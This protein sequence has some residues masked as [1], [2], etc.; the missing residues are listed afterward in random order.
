MPML[1]LIGVLF[2]ANAW[3]GWLLGYHSVSRYVTFWILTALALATA[4]NTVTRVFPA[5]SRVDAIIRVGVV[6]FAVV[7]VAGVLLGSAG[8]LTIAGRPALQT[9]MC[10]AAPFAPA[11][12]SGLTPP[13]RPP[14][15]L[16]PA[17]LG[18]AL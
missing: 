2:A 16:V 17:A 18:A 3:V 9:P 11:R 7:V 10:A 14:A 13:H 15:S 6:T 12:A 8:R 1:T 5:V 4:W